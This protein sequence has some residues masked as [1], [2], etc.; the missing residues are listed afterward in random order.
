HYERQKQSGALPV[1]GVNTFLPHTQPIQVE[2]SLMRSSDD[3]KQHQI[4]GLKA[5]QS[6]NRHRSEAAL[7]KLM[8][9]AHNGGNLFAELMDTVRWCSLGQ[10]TEAL[11]R[12]GGRYRR[13]M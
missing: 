3:E 1:I 13:S 11:F 2:Q 7:D 6:R 12:V 9:T 5:F 4:A 8:N 10:I